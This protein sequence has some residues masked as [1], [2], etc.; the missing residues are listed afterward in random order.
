MSWIPEIVA[1]ILLAGGA[2]TLSSIRRRLLAWP[3]AVILLGGAYAAITHVHM[4]HG[5]RL[6][7]I[8]SWPI[9]GIA[10]WLLGT[11]TKKTARRRQSRRP[12][13]RG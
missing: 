13:V 7:I 12:Q 4:T 5:Q 1:T 11:L 6:V 8:I 3:I 10:G 9:A 2:A